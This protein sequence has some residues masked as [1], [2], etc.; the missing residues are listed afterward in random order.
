MTGDAM[1]TL[2]LVDDEPSIANGLGKLLARRGHSVAIAL[3]SM[4]ATEILTTRRIDILL[5]DYRMPDLRGDI[6]YAKAVALQPHLQ[7]RTIFLTGDPSDDVQQVI[8]ETGCPLLMKPFDIAELEAA[9][10]RLVGAI[11]GDTNQS[12]G[13]A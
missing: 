12:V 2:L 7:T 1:L 4:S 13:A 8:S 10:R 5:I 6:L 11:G 9:L 3:N